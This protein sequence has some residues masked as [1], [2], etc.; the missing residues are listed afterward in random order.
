M[1]LINLT[2][3][4][5][6]VSFDLFGYF[7]IVEGVVAMGLV[8]FDSAWMTFSENDT[9]CRSM[10]IMFENVLRDRISKTWHQK[11]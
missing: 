6:L 5:H 1:A 9:L 8:L 3:K 2:L 11:G 4:T 10:Q 7:S